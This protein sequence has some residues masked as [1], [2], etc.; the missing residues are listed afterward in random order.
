MKKNL[1][2]NLGQNILDPASLKQFLNHCVNNKEY[3]YHTTV[4]EQNQD[5]TNTKIKILAEN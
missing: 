4:F 1:F 3:I 5:G 2:K